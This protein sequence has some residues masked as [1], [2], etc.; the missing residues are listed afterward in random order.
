MFTF[1]TN[2]SVNATMQLLLATKLRFL[3]DDYRYFVQ[4]SDNAKIEM[5]SGL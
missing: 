3:R 4:R 2:L 5:I 1:L